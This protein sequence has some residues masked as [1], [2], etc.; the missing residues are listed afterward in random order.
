MTITSRPESDQVPSSHTVRKQSKS[1]E[2]SNSQFISATSSQSTLESTLPVPANINNLTSKAQTLFENI[3]AGVNSCIKET[4]KKSLQAL[5]GLVSMANRAATALRCKESASDAITKKRE[6]QDVTDNAA[7]L[8]L[9]LNSLISMPRR[10]SLES[11][12]SMPKNAID[13]TKPDNLFD[14]SRMLYRGPPVNLGRLPIDVGPKV[15]GPKI[16]PDDSTSRL[17]DETSR[18][19]DEGSLTVE[20]GFQNVKSGTNYWE[21]RV[22]STFKL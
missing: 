7:A 3:K 11:R 19:S 15:V 14:D 12:V 21:N 1:S 5:K 8:N 6:L 22:V 2:H 20:P 18:L 16:D 10:P 13:N 17:S 4:G 9:R